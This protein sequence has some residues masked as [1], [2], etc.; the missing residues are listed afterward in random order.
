[1]KR[2]QILAIFSVTL[3]V[4]TASGFVAETAGKAQ[5]N[6]SGSKT[7]LLLEYFTDLLDGFTVYLP[8]GR[9]GGA[10]PSPTP[11]HPP[12]EMVYVPASDFQMG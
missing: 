9:S 8:I 1:M 5:T 2:I 7:G 11:E 3:L 12:D 4:L 10:A 6:R